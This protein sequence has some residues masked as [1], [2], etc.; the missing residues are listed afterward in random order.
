MRTPAKGSHSFERRA[1]EAHP[2]HKDRKGGDLFLFT[3]LTV[4]RCPCPFVFIYLFPLDAPVPERTPPK[5]KGKKEIGEPRSQHFVLE[6]RDIE[7]VT[8]SE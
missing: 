5:K 2:A 8:R 4:E 1:S 3:H 6:S 7:I